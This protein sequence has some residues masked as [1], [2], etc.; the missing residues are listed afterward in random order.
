[1]AW[2]GLHIDTSD[3][4][5]LHAQLERGIRVAIA[6]GTLK[7]GDKL[8]TVRQLAVDLRVNANTVAKVYAYLE[9]SGAVETRRGVGTFIAG[10]NANRHEEARDAALRGLALRVLADAGRLGFSSEDVLRQIQAVT[11][12]HGRENRVKD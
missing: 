1:M 2:Q 6:T 7:Q 10:G 5:P 3:A 9:R 4:T 12:E 8:P 11:K